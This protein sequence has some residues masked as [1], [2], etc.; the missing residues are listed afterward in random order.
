MA[1][2]GVRW[3]MTGQGEP[4]VATE[5]N[6]LLPEPDEVV[7]EVAG[8]GVCHTDLGYYY[9]GVR[10]NHGLPLALGH[11]ISGRVVATGAGAEKWQGKAVIVPAV[12]PCGECELCRSGHGTICRKQQMPGNDIQG[13]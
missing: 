1:N 10:V 11:E 8:C 13:G 4:M 12:I 6:P 7:V 5:F 3:M 9:D 2:A